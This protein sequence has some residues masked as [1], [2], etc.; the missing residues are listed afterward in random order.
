MVIV[1]GL[2]FV[3]LTTALGFA[4]RGFRVY[5][6]DENQELIR[7]LKAGIYHGSEPHI[8]QM[9]SKHINHNFIISAFLICTLP[10]AGSLSDRLKKAERHLPLRL[11][12]T[13]NLLVQT[14][15]FS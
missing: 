1:F 7:Q 2:G 8:G 9:L 3:G 6:F 14:Y 5:G 11:L 15:C 10:A 12:Y 4:E 13:P